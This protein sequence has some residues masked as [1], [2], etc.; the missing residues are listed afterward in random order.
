V[1]ELFS[2]PKSIEMDHQTRA[3]IENLGQ[4]TMDLISRGG[5]SSNPSPA[6]FALSSLLTITKEKVEGLGD[7]KLVLM[8]SRFTRH[9]GSK[10]GCYNYGDPEHFIARCPKKGK[11][12]AGP[13]DHHSGRCK[14]KREYTSSK[15]KS[16]GG[17]DKEALKKY[18]QKVK[19]KECPLSPP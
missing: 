19:I 16:K 11:Q 1:D 7:E 5:S 10:D 8:A 3:K 12:E 14:G 13:R 2:K 15:H 18:L 4:S 9:G 6:M 17:F